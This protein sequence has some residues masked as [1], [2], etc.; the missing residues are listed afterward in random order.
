MSDTPSEGNNGTWNSIRE[1]VVCSITDMTGREFRLRLL[2]DTGATISSLPAYTLWFTKAKW[3]C[4]QIRPIP[5]RGINSITACDLIC[6]APIKPGR[7]LSKE[8][9]DKVNM[10]DNFQ[11]NVDFYIIRGPEVYT[12]YKCELPKAIISTL[13]NKTYYLADPEQIAPR[14]SLLYIHGIL[15]VQAIQQMKRTA[16]QA[17]PGTD[18]TLCR[19]MFGD[20]LFGTSHFIEDRPVT[21]QPPLNDNNMRENRKHTWCSDSFWSRGLKIDTSSQDARN[22]TAQELE[23]EAQTKTNP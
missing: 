21:T 15:G 8:F 17:V 5:I 19:S 12:T 14:D 16:F 1:T 6:H 22:V 7:H 23:K 10:P 9:R 18:M 4:E 2:V 20:L 3:D 13:S 11:I